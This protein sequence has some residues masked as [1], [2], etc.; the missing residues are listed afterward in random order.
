MELD[1]VK[2]LIQNHGLDG[3]QYED[4]VEGCSIICTDCITCHTTCFIKTE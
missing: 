1:E 2:T 3:I 4:S